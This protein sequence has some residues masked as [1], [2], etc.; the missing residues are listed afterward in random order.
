MRILRLAAL[1]GSV[2]LI[3]AAAVGYVARRAQLASE[4]DLTVELVADTVAG[5]LTALTGAVELAATMGDD[6]REAEALIRQFAPEADVTVRAADGP[7]E[8]EL[9]SVPNDDGRFEVV[10]TGPAL[11]VTA[12]VDVDSVLAAIPRTESV[13]GIDVSLSRSVA[14]ARGTVTTLGDQRVATVIVPGADAVAVTASA[15]D[16]VVL[17]PDERWLMVVIF[18]LAVLLLVLAG[19]TVFTEQRTLVERAS[20]D[21]LTRLP[22]RSEFEQRAEEILAAARRTETGVCLLLFDLDGFKA[23]NDTHGHQAGDDV[24]R[25]MGARLRNAVR[26]TDV[27]ARWGGDEF[28]LV[29]QGLEESTLARQRAAALGDLISGEPVGDGLYVGASVGIAMFPRHGSTLAELVE[30]ADGAMYAAKRDGVTHRMAGVESSASVPVPPA[31]DRR[32]GAGLR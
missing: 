1:L 15:P 22:N 18:G 23:I 30:A 20:I 26:E 21:P 13:P 4:R 25:T 14:E 31:A 32:A 16:D 24:L 7:A 3:V 6:P 5:E 12:T 8:V 11:T 17:D 27:V 19:A 9:V 29:L 10:A 28:V 2:A